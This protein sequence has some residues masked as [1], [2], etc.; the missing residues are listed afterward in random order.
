MSDEQREKLRIAQ[1]AYIE[2]DPRWA[3]HKEKLADAQRKPEQ[4]AVLAERMRDYM[5]TDP[6]WPEH[7]AKLIE[8]NGSSMNRF[9]LLPE[10]I[11]LLKVER[12]KGRTLS[13][14]A[15]AFS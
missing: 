2:N 9:T 6:R 1:L 14:L 7:Q 10:E 13:Y 3:A 11:E 12:A 4:K 8:S 15:E 5:E